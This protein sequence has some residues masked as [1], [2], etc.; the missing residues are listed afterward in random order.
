MIVNCCVTGNNARTSAVTELKSK[1]VTP[2]VSS[3]LA[4][5]FPSMSKKSSQALNVRW[6]VAG[7]PVVETVSV[8]SAI[9]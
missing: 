2:S 5:S 4:L 3:L 8:T 1:V 9:R 6:N 7:I